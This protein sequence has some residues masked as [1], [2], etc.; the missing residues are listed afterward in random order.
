MYKDLKQSKKHSSICDSAK[1]HLSTK[2]SSSKLVKDPEYYSSI[3]KVND[4]DKIDEVPE[5]SYNESVN[6]NA[7]NWKNKANHHPNDTRGKE[8]FE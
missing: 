8:S 1:G 7:F 6:S 4:F 2:F 3:K 5:S